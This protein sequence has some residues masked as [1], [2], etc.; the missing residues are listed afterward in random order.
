MTNYELKPCPISE[1]SNSVSFMA[2]I[3]ASKC[4]HRKKH[5]RE[6]LTE[7]ELQIITSDI[8]DSMKYVK[9][10]GTGKHKRNN[11]LNKINKLCKDI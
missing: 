10:S 7:D 11:I 3:A 6:I 9:M 8:K 1:Y 4:P 2:A 5:I